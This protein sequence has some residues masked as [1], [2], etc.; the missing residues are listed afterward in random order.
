MRQKPKSNSGESAAKTTEEASLYWIGWIGDW[1]K[2]V[3]VFFSLW[4]CLSRSIRSSSFREGEE[5]LGHAPRSTS[6]LGPI[7]FVLA[8]LP[9]HQPSPGFLHSSSSS[10]KGR[11]GV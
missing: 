1:E 9:K 2:E 6:K 10:S 8:H 7:P 11:V 4:A 5:N 3:V